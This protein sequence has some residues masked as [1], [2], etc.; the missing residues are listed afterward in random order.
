VVKKR[1]LREKD[2]NEGERERGRGRK[3]IM[4]KKEKRE[5]LKR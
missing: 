1:T 2:D 3:K 5:E 4:N